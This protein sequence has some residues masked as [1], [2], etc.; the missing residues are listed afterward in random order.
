MNRRRPKQKRERVQAER[1][2]ELLLK[3]CGDVFTTGKPADRV[4]SSTFRG[5]KKY[6]SNDRRFISTTF[7]A[8][9]RWWGWLQL[10]P[11]SVDWESDGAPIARRDWI[12]MLLAAHV[13]DTDALHP[14]AAEWKGMLKADKVRLPDYV[15]CV[16][17]AEEI[18]ARA[19]GLTAIFPR[20]KPTWQDLT[21][22]WIWGHVPLD[23]TGRG[24]VTEWLQYRPPLWL[25]AYVDDVDAL[26]EQ[27]TEE[28]LGAERSDVLPQAICVGHSRVNLFELES[29]K[30]GAFEVQDAASQCIGLACSASPGQRW[31]DVCAGGGG[32]SLQLASAMTNKGSLTAT[33]IRGWKLKDLKKRARR[34]KLHNITAKEWDGKQVKANAYD[35]VLVDAPCTCSGTWRRNPDARWTMKR[36]DIDELAATQLGILQRVA[37]SV[38]PDGVLVYA[39][40]S[41]FIDENEDVV[42][43]FLEKHDDF[44]LEPFLNPFA[45]EPTDGTMRVWPDAS[46]CD[47]MFVARFRRAKG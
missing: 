26:V 42:T 31:W 11:R 5:Q 41:M 8:L 4:L 27:L 38:R 21:P 30:N 22:A 9:F 1:Y 13:L 6:G 2:A 12:S 46:D 20:V 24:L 23:K 45:D 16:G 10:I 18:E 40:C 28:R 29:F 37:R 17:G 44:E 36:A 43:G 3:L 34:A 47:A 7:Y 33:D 32:K 25:R 14:I 39:T 35:G 19:A 15:Q